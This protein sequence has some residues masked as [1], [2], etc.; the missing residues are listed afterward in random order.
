MPAVH[1][2][3]PSRHD[4]FANLRRVEAERKVFDWRGTQDMEVLVYGKKRERKTGD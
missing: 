4:P 2:S 3:E 1:S